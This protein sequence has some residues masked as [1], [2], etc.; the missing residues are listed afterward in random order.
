MPDLDVETIV[1][2]EV[3]ASICSEAAR[4]EPTTPTSNRHRREF[5]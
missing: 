1:P 2:A 3:E 4:I 5:T